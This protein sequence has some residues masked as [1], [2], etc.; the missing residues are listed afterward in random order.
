MTVTASLTGTADFGATLTAKGTFAINDGSTLKS[1]QWTQT[2]GV[3][4]TIASPNA[5]TTT[6]VLSSLSDY[7]NHLLQ[8]LKSPPITAADLPPNVKLQ[9]IN[10][11]NKG[12]QDRFQVVGINNMALDEGTNVTLQFTVTTTSGTYSATAVAAVK[13]PWTVNPGLETV[14][15]DVSVLLQ[16]KC[17]EALDRR[18]KRT[19]VLPLDPAAASPGR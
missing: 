18:L 14:P 7:K 2:E 16:A 13:L 10:Y 12:L 15:I 5:A 8:V 17:G 11:V 1:I 3:P 6:V 19:S 9:S 4:A